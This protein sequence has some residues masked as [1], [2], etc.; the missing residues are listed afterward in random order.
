MVRLRNWFG[1][2]CSVLLLSGAATAEPVVFYFDEP[3]ELKSWPGRLAVFADG[4]ARGAVEALVA[5][6][7][8]ADARIEGHTIGG[9]YF[10]DAPAAANNAAATRAIAETLSQQAQG[11]GLFVTDVFVDEVGGPMFPTPWVMVGFAPEVDPAHALALL[12]ASGFGED[13]QQDFGGLANTYRARTSLDSGLAVLSAAADLARRADTIY[14]EPDMSFTGKS[15]LIPN[16]PGFGFCWGLDNTGQ[17]GCCAG[18]DMGA[19]DAWDTTTGSNAIQTIVIDTGVQ[20]NH[21]DINQSAGIDTTSESNPGGGPFNACDNHGTP[22]AGCVSATINNNLGTVGIAPATRTR[23]ARAMITDTGPCDGSWSAFGSWTVL[24]IEYAGTVNARVTNNSNQYGFTS[25]AIASAYQTAR[26]NGIVHFAS[27][28]NNSDTNVTYPANLPTVNAVAAIDPDGTLTSFSTSGVGL[29]FA[30]PGIDVY[31]TDRTGSAGYVGGSYVFVNGTSFASPYAAG[32]AALILSVNPNLTPV[33]VENLMASTAQDLGTSGYDTTFGWGLPRADIAVLIAAQAVSCGGTAAGSCCESNGSPNC[34]NAACCQAVCAVDPFCCNTNWDT[35]CA[36]QANELCVTCGG[37]GCGAPDAGSC[38]ESNGTPFCDNAECCEAV[39]AVDPFCCNTSWDSACATNAINLCVTCGGGSCGA[40][41]SGECCQANGTP[42]C[43]DPECC[44][45]VCAVDPFCCNNTWDDLCAENA[46]N[47]CVDCFSCGST[48]A[49]SCCEA[50]GTPYCDNAACCE[51]VC[52]V[53]PFCCDTAWDTACANNAA[54]NCGTLCVTACE[55][56][57][58]NDG[59]VNT[60]DLG[61]LLGEFGCAGAACSADINEDG[62]VNTED[63][64]LLL[65]EFGCEG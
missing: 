31:S 63:L 59:V 46:G 30:A 55:A 14:A 25:S 48:D 9:W 4:Q 1:F 10:V 56:D 28:G 40:P 53:D 52:A 33:Q 6:A 27:A 60:E 65:G 26:N 61:L 44:E 16:D 47:L 45:T 15:S 51:A 21:P 49:G 13:I 8:V 54:A 19:V 7:G 43:N 37:G 42:F 2:C 17:A 35:T 57:I 50:N 36:N 5:D 34:N 62:V 29:A 20:Q 23:S 39:C 58:N 64:G 22:V 3:R 12:E 32:V 41:D 18:I 24:A 11:R 38:C